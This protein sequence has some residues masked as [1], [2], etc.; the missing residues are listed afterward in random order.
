MHCPR[1]V[2]GHCPIC[3]TQMKRW[4]TEPRISS[5]VTPI[6]STALGFASTMTWLSAS[7]TRMPT[8]AV[9]RMAARHWRLSASSP[10]NRSPSKLRPASGRQE[11]CSWFVW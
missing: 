2:I 9:A 7:M 4:Q 3:E 11:C 8:C 6:T 1:S 5:L 10:W